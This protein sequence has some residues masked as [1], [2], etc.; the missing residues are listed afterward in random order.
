WF[1]FATVTFSLPTPPH[2]A[3]G[4]GRR[5]LYLSSSAEFSHGQTDDQTSTSRLLSSQRPAGSGSG[6]P[7]SQNPSQGQERSPSAAGGC[8]GRGSAHATPAR[9]RHRHRFPLALG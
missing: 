1:P 5:S 3:S 7:P 6:P 4:H 2:T 9:R 8:P